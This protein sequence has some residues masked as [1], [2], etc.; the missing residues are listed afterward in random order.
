MA[1]ALAVM[2]SFPPDNVAKLSPKDYDKEM[3]TYLKNLGKLQQAQWLKQID[4]Q[5]ILELLNPSVNSIPYAATL[6]EQIKAMG[7]DK[8]RLDYLFDHTLIFFASFDPVQVRYLGEQWNQLLD[9]AMGKLRTAGIPD[10]SPIAGAMLRLDPTAG[11]FTTN[12]L[13]LLRA[14]LY[15]GVPSQALPILDKNIYAFPTLPAKN[16][17]E[18]LLSEEHELSNGFITAKSSF[19]EKVQTEHVLEYH[20]LG[21]HI[22]IG[23]R[24]YT[25]ARLFLEYLIL[26]PSQ[27][28][29]V[30]ALQVEAY[31]KWVLV[32]LL[33]E[34]K[35][36]PLPRTHDGPV[37]KSIRAIAKAYDALGDTFEK[38]DVRKFRAE[39]DVGAAIWH[40]DGNLR[41][42]REAG[43]ALLRYR[44]IDLQKTFAALPVSRVASHMEFTEDVTL[45]MLTDMIRGGSLNASIT[46]GATSGE[47]VLRFHFTQSG[48]SSSMA[49]EDELEA[50]TKRIEDLVTF[51]RDADR[52]LQLTK[53]Y[54]EHQKRAKRH[55]AGP[56]G[57]LADQMD[58]TW[59]APVPGLDDGDEDIM[60]S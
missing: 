46:P 59:D 58:L 45:Q 2:L 12:H 55:G 56:D 60:A 42:V 35:A 33:A 34:G 26:T 16:V 22:Y 53:E 3:G 13:K 27:Q 57:D 1:D 38:R 28:Y 37:M 31:K 51:I 15:S 20:L 11:T 14:C 17:P 48:P 24:N 40:E 6:V 18:E 19:T 39:M 32:G 8:S 44:V 29:A 9:W 21:A 5:N 49:Q 30:S 50:Q 47:A 41:M 36:Y 7:K 25:R 23:Q 43:D 10:L 52:R 4:K 54:V